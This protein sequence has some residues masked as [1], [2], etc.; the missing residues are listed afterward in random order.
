MSGFHTIPRGGT[1]ILIVTDY[2]VDRKSLSEAKSIDF[3]TKLS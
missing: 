2:G 3:V 1:E